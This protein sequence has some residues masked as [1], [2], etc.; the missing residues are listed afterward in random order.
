MPEYVVMPNSEEEIVSIVKLL[1]RY[2]I[3]Y[4][5]RGNGASSHGL[6]FTEGVVLD[7]NRMKTIEFNEKNWFVKVGA[8]CRGVRSSNG[9]KEARL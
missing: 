8:G 4:I 6:V 3:P 9:S 1:N 7:L 5:V 2:N